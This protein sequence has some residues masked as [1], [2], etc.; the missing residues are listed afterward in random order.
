MWIPNFT[1]EFTIRLKSREAHLVHFEI[2]LLIFGLMLSILNYEESSAFKDIL[3]IEF[4]KQFNREIKY[5]RK[6]GNLQYLLIT[7]SF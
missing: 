3:P 7:I 4:A 1:R 5:S 2:S 6:K